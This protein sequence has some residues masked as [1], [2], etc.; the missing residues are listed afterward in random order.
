MDT[1]K[2][3][4]RHCILFAF[5]RGLSGAAA[6][7]EICDVYGEDS[8]TKSTCDRWYTKFRSGDTSLTDQ[9]RDGRPST[10]SDGVLESLLAANPRQTTRELA[11]QLGC[12]HTTVE[13]HL[14]A[15][16]K[17]Q[18]YGSWLPHEL[19]ANNKIQ[20]V[21]TCVSLL[22]RYHKESFLER[23]VTGD[24]KW[25]LYVNVC[26]KKQWLDPEQEPLSDAKADLH[27][28]KVLLCIW[29]DLKGILYYEF[30]N[31]NTT[32]NAE[33]YAHQL[34]RVQEALRQKR[35]A[36]VNRKGVILLDDNARPH[37]AKMTRHKIQELGWEVLPHP[38]YSP[39]LAPSDY[40]LFRSLQNHLAEKCFEDLDALNSDLAAF[41]DSKEPVFYKSGIYELPKRWTTVVDKDGEYIVD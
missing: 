25:L 5:N 37:V 23:I 17:V 10:I 18:K 21:S 22:C 26:R 2:L 29:W 31:H 8:T 1:E 11:E 12:T 9:P 41:F 20:R 4:I 33:I 19:S 13:N 3:H 30:L 39:D 28:T 35:P 15:L 34:Q 27:P 6:A 14:H 7:K 40:H 36:L 16:G 38:P 32:I 24:E